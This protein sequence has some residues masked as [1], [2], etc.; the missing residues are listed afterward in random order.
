MRLLLDTHTLLWWLDGDAQLPPRV[1][2]EIRA[3]DNTIA[4]SAASAWEITI[5]WRLGKLPG[6]ALVASDVQGALASQGL[7]SLAI[8]VQHAEHAGRLPGPHRDPFDR[9][10][11]A[12]AQLEG[13][14]VDTAT[15]HPCPAL[16]RPSG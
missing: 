9:M 16:P 4:V 6:A 14:V 3:T 10:L 11:V 12:Q 1:R 8:S 13:F 7:S 5:K 15:R 2:R